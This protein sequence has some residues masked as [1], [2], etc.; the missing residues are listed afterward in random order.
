MT[1]VLA[2][3]ITNDFASFDEDT[4]EWE[5]DVLEGMSGTTFRNQRHTTPIRKFNCTIIGDITDAKIANTVALKA[6]AFGRLYGFNLT[7]PFTAA[8]IPVAFGRDSWTR[9]FI[10]GESGKRKVQLSFSLEEVLDGVAA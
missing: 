9:K 10:G 6:S 1:I 2:T 7:H 3:Y 5:T 4:G 8:V